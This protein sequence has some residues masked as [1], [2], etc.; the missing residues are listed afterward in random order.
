MPRNYQVLNI[1]KTYAAGI[2]AAGKSDSADIKR[3]LRRSYL[4][5]HNK[6]NPRSG[7]GGGILLYYLYYF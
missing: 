2:S 3:K 1:H 5:G 4:K 6:Q 7:M